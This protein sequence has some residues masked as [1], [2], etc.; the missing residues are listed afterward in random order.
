MIEMMSGWAERA[1][2]LVNIVGLCFLISR[3][4][5]DCR[6]ALRRTPYERDYVA[7]DVNFSDVFALV[8]IPFCWGLCRIDRNRKE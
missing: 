7:T 4:C 5:N 1:R 2:V 8:V 3:S 6:L